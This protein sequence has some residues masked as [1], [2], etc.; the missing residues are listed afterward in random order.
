MEWA[1]TPMLTTPVL[2]KEERRVPARYQ[3]PH[4]HQ[5]RGDATQL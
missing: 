3:V 5:I 1:G 2:A 4:L